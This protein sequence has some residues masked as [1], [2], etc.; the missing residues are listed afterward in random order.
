MYVPAD[1]NEP[2]PDA[3]RELI[4]QHPFGSLITHGKS[5][6]DAN[7][8]PFELMPDDGGLGELHAHVARAN[9]VWQDVADGD[10][11]LVIFRAGDAYI[12]PNWYPSKHVAHR[13]VP[14]WNYRVVHA[15]GRVTVRDD[16]K[17]V[18]GVV[19]R[20]TRTHEASQP[21]PWK[22]GD[23]PPD[24]IATMLQAIV[25]L[26]IEITRLVGKRKLGQ[27]KAEADIRGAG[28]ALV[29]DGKLA[30]GEAMVTEADAKRE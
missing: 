12:S 28:E 11:V 29:A 2:N 24:Y 13:Q 1:F 15:H 5:G 7:H 6:L 9:P 8:I 22:M 25:G 23:A 3:L 21:V 27:N 16:E 20:L 26:Q 4:V 10:E 14:T 19:A 17:F 18:R 30:I